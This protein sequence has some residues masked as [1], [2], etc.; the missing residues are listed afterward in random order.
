M[1]GA[2][3]SHDNLC[4]NVDQMEARLSLRASDIKFTWMPHYHDMGLIGCHLLP[5]AVGASQVRMQAIE[6]VSAR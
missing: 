3:L 1:A 2:V 5:L 4:V 6:A